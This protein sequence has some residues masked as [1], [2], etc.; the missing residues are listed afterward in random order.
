MSERIVFEEEGDRG[1]IKIMAIGTVTPDLLDGVASYIARQREREI[2]A[3]N[4]EIE[5]ASWTAEKSTYSQ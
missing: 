3:A 5:V 1:H 2:A 4:G